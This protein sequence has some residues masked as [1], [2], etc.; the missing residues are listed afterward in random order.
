M[1]VH[2]PCAC[3]QVIHKTLD[4]HWDESFEFTCPSLAVCVS[5]P[6]EVRI[7]DHDVSVLEAQLGKV[8]QAGMDAMPAPLARAKTLSSLSKP[9]SSSKALSNLAAIA[10]SPQ[11]E[12]GQDSFWS[13]RQ[14]A[15]QPGPGPCRPHQ[16]LGAGQHRMRAQAKTA[17]YRHAPPDCTP[18]SVVVC[19][20]VCGL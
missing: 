8:S 14:A 15:R 9:L 10:G 12:A 4:P 11:G 17:A 6:L 19:V 20:I 3:A 13:A 7:Y 16:A 5:R 2:V 1:H 18:P